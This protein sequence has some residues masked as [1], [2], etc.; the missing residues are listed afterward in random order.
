VRERERRR[1]ICYDEG[2]LG[3]NSISEKNF[4]SKEKGW[5]ASKSKGKM[6]LLFI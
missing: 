1:E 3:S 6:F 5:Q 2:N 4:W